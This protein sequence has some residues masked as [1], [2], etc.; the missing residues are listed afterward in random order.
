MI[1][2]E[3]LNE[4]K[5]NQDMKIGFKNAFVYCGKN[6]MNVKRVLEELSSQEFERLNNEL[7][8]KE[9]HL[10]NFEPYWE[11]RINAAL[12][13]IKN[14]AQKNK[15]KKELIEK[16]KKDLVLTKEKIKE[17]KYRIANYTSFLKREVN[18]MYDSIVEEDEKIIRCNGLENGLYWTRYEYEQAR[19]DRNYVAELESM[20]L[21]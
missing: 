5:P 21:E 18:D 8:T 9:K 19:R 15:K 10:A 12:E 2:E 6:D 3:L 11:R 7:K 1:L 20:E 4:L 13:K 16:R 17:Y 14:K